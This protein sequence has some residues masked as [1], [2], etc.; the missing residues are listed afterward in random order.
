MYRAVS[1]GSLLFDGDADPVEWVNEHDWQPVGQSRRRALAGNLH[2]VENPRG[3]RP[4]TLY[5]DPVYCW[6]SAAQVAAL[7]AMAS[8]V[9]A[10]YTLILRP[11]SGPDLSKSVMFDR[12]Q[13]PLDLVPEDAWGDDYSGSIYL[14]EV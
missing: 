6:L 5:A 13:K 8:Q 14:V 9:G 11:E 3:G 10:S 4:I 12:S 7:E 2:I 1:L